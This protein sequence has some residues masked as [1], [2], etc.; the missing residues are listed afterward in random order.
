MNT[1]TTLNVGFFMLALTMLACS[2]PQ[3]DLPSQ[4][5]Y[6]ENANGDL[7]MK[8]I[9]VEGGTFQ[10]GATSEQQGLKPSD[11]E[12]PPHYV[13]L[14]SYYIGECEVTQAQWERIMG[15]SIY[16]QRD[17]AYP[18]NQNISDVGDNYPMYFISW[19]DAQNFCEEL[20]R[21]TGKNYMLPTE[22]QWEFAARESNNSSGSKYSGGNSI[23][24]IAW[25]GSNSDERVHQVKQKRPN[26][27]GLYDMSGNLWEWCRDWYDSEYYLY[28]EKTNPEGPLSGE[29]RLLRG[30]SWKASDWSCR[31]SCRGRN[32][33]HES[34]TTF[35][36]R[37][38]CIP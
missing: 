10:M 33:A 12:L 29:K 35:G 22:A 13:T 30:G 2:K 7:G 26:R 37:V 28:S 5:N 27:L 19:E 21:I 36:F 1:K 34:F 23:D 25:Y 8:M 38:V 20:S 31:V 14:S 3:T 18:T 6:V 11:D 32:V 15:T 9:Y 24:A 16:Q 17:K 4:L